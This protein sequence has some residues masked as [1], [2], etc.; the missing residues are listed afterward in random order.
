MPLF[1]VGDQVERVGSFV[2]DYMKFGRVVR[3]IP[4][5]ALPDFLTEYEVDFEYLMDGHTCEHIVGTFYQTQL[6]LARTSGSA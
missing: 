2:P 1:K 4:N 5:R 6:R 3:I